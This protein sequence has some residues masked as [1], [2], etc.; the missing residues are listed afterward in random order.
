[1]I[2]ADNV[3]HVVSVLHFIRSRYQPSIYYLSVLPLP[4]IQLWFY[5]PWVVLVTKLGQPYLRYDTM[6]HLCMIMY[7]L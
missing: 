5:G 7:I 3:R 2:Q 1:M 6:P 4:D